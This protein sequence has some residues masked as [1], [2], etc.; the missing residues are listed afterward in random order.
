MDPE[1]IFRQKSFYQLLLLAIPIGLI[2]GL[3]AFAFLTCVRFGTIALWTTLAGLLNITRATENPWFIFGVTSIGGLLVGLCTAFFRARGEVHLLQE[4]RQE[5]HIDFRKV[6]GTLITAFFSLAVGASVGPEASFIDLAAGIGSFLAVRFRRS[7]EQARALT[8]TALSAVFGAFFDSPFGSAF[9]AMELPHTQ[10]LRFYLLIFP[11]IIASIMT[12]SLFIFLAGGTLG[13]E[14]TFPPYPGFHFVYLLY[15]IPLGIV[16]ALAGLVFIYLFRELHYLM[17]PLEHHTVIRGVIGGVVFGLIAMHFPLT[18]FS[19]E[20]QLETLLKTGLR[21]G[22][23]SLLL[24]GLMKIIATCLC[25]N[26]GFV[27]GRIFPAFFA[28]G[29]IGMAIYLLFPAIPLAVCMLCVLSALA[30]SIMKIPVSMALIVSALI[31]PGLAPIIAIAIIISFLLTV[32][33][34][35]LPT[36]EAQQHSLVLALFARLRPQPPLA[37]E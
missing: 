10:D 37:T 24:L 6:P 29:A 32:N 34:P 30:V 28:G 18:L 35:L 36:R 9:L 15:A 3:A 2:V 17:R 31:Q 14:Y 16:G 7:A 4:I 20:Q 12:Y 8:L 22:F 27:G 25:I 1:R 19:G 13:G 21:M 26:A 5:G 33:I 11:G 23:F